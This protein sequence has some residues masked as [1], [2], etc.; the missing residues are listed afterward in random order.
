MTKQKEKII[1]DTIKK[2]LALLDIKAEFAIT[3]KEEV[4][5]IVFETEEGGLLIGYHGETLEGLQT[6]I[7]LCISK[8]IGEFTRVSVEVGDYKKNRIEYLKQ[9]VI[10]TKEQVLAEQKEIALTDLKSWER[11]IV[12]T[13]L[14]EDSEVQST[15][16]GE[17]RERVLV[18]H[19]KQ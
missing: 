3:E 12:H 15:S 13:L 11:K 4:V 10:S 7:S 16:T 19:P 18:I 14:Q 2:L 8:K 17:G 6:I 1:N 9:L 5:E